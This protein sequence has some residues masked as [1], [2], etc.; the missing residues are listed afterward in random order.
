VRRRRA[1]SRKPAKAKKTIKAKRDAAPKA[2]RNRRLSASSKNTEVA[3]L[4]R[5][6]DDT[7]EQLSATSEVLRVISRSPGEL[8]PVFTT[9]LGNAVRI[10]RAKFGTLYLC[11]DNGFRAVAI[12]NAPPG[13]AE[14]RAGVVHPPPDSPFGCAVRTKQVTQVADVTRSRAYIEG[15]PFVVSA[16]ELGRYRT[17]ISVP[18]LKENELIG[19]INIY[20]QEV[21]PFADKQIELVQ[22]FAAQAVIAIENA[23]LLNE[24]RQRTADL[25]E[26]LQQQTATSEV[27][28]VI[29]S[30]PGELAPV[31]GAI[32]ANAIQIC[33]A[34]FGNL[35]L[36][37]GDAYRI[38]A[39]HNT[40]PALI[41]FFRRAPIRPGPT[42]PISRAAKER[43]PVQSMDVTTE[44]FYVDGDSVA[45]AGAKLGGT[46][47]VLAV[48]MLKE[49]ELVG[50]IVIFHQEVCPFTNKQIELVKNFAAQAVIAIEN[51][52]LLNELRESL[53]QQTA[54]ADVLKVIS[55]STGELEPVFRAM[56]ENA[57]R[58]CGAHF[59]SLWRFEHGVV[60]L[61]SNFNHPL[62]FAKFLQ[63]GSHRPGPHNPIT[64]VVK[65]SQVVH[66]VDYCNDQAYL[67]H[68]PLAVAGVEI[69]GIRTLLVVP[70]IRDDELLGAI[71]IFH[72]EVRPFTEK[73][74]A[75]VAS[76]ASQ[77]VIAIENTRL[78]NELRESLQQQTAT[79]D[80]LKVISRS[81]FDLKS[82][83]QTLV[84][85]AARLCDAD[86]GN[87]TRQ[88]DGVFY[89]AEFYG[90]PAEVI[91]C[92]RKVP[93]TPERGNA[94]GRA[95]LEGRTVHIPDVEADPNY[96]FDRAGTGFRSV[97]GVPMLREGAPIGVLAL[98]RSEVRPF[99]DKQIDLV[100]TFAD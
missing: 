6:R 59:G 71:G 66:I 15:D 79:A 18:M 46:R 56:L 13:F 82:V 94:S 72:Q 87:I 52:R 100:S 74:I 77:A 55:T 67:D 26:S 30:S 81:T 53:Q 50:V 36:C 22:N 78:L 27:L 38:S 73:Q 23:R 97:L 58:I 31:F 57:T 17:V 85:S 65:T 41:E 42:L 99:T 48:P 29:S 7:V 47:T 16:V 64:R 1:T 45:T 12:H 93:I 8:E 80:V 9:I 91:E 68:D 84:E 43:R 5:E 2:A 19:A 25:S 4:T 39:Y 92:W 28:K 49:S 63:Q 95:L 86:K 35:F 40:P 20:R 37:E 34:K 76:F 3:R 54:T 11:E 33:G 61:V 69:G 10:C 75:L 83:L 98:S 21:R 90:F 24:L 70:M 14:A 51:T 62:A 44:Q 96:S 60:R 88:V 32:L 89:R